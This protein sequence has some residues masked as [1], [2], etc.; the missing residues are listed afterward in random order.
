MDY[1]SALNDWKINIAANSDIREDKKRI[2][3]TIARKGP[4]LCELECCSMKDSLGYE[5]VISEHAIPFSLSDFQNSIVILTDEAVYFGTTFQRIYKV[6]KTGILLQRDLS[7]TPNDAAILKAAPVV[8][9]DKAS[10]LLNDN[11]DWLIQSIPVIKEEDTPEY[12]NSLIE[13]FY[14]LGKPFDIEFPILYARMPEKWRMKSNREIAEEL[15]KVLYEVELDGEVA[16]GQTYILQH[17]SAYLKKEFYTVTR[18]FSNEIYQNNKTVHSEFVKIRAFWKDDL[19]AFAFYAPRIIDDRLLQEEY[20]PLFENT[21]YQ[22]IWS[23]LWNKAHEVAGKISEWQ[24]D[25]LK[26]NLYD[27]NYT[28]EEYLYHTHRSLLIWTNYMFSFDLAVKLIGSLK[29]RLYDNNS[30]VLSDFFLNKTD[31]RYLSGNELLNGI[32]EQ[33]DTIIKS[34]EEIVLPSVALTD[35]QVNNQIPEPYR[36]A[37]DLKNVHDLPKCGNMSQLISALFYN[38]HFQVELKGRENWKE[39][40]DRLRFG[41]T[42]SSIYNRGFIRNFNED[43]YTSMHKAMDF[44]IDNGSIVPKYIRRK[45]N[46]ID[47]WSRV[48]RCGENE[49]FYNQKLIRF[50]ERILLY[51]KDLYGNALL[52]EY[53]IY[54]MIPVYLLPTSST[55]SMFKDEYLPWDFICQWGS[56]GPE[57][58]VMNELGDSADCR[59]LNNVQMTD[60]IMFCI[61]RQMLNK[62]DVEGYYTIVTDLPPASDRWKTLTQEKMEIITKFLTEDMGTLSIQDITEWLFY[63]EEVMV[64]TRSKL[65]KWCNKYSEL[66]EKCMEDLSF[67]DDFNSLHLVYPWK[68]EEVIKKL[69]K[70]NID[71]YD[72]KKLSMNL[73]DWIQDTRDKWIEQ[74]NNVTNIRFLKENEKRGNNLCNLLTFCLYFNDKKDK[75]MF[76][77]AKELDDYR[78]SI[79]DPL[80]QEYALSDILIKEDYDSLKK[81]YQSFIRTIVNDMD[82][83]S[84][85]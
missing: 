66:T 4:R 32:Y 16:H 31:I 71:N 51:I 38:M 53:L 39:N 72:S 40:L 83:E 64:N 15:K 65:L 35:I 5:Y 23:L 9:S 74:V 63:S 33:L 36:N 62:S 70:L 73:L 81:V 52:P 41:E 59:H 13:S 42:F 49:D 54:G 84:G 79:G 8:V 34:Q 21:P 11:V 67:I 56:Y 37:Y 75:A 76:E 30:A 68:K 6:L 82:I 55:E 50:M 60:L 46:G 43:I 27:I 25:A 57:V 78:I 69:K 61:D 47:I 7:F 24:N 1:K 12:V 58:F 3:V 77:M 20:S 2:C 80:S 44:R 28:L 22:K 18:L 19:L 45:N 10:S 48:F 29:H 17:K 85:L 26:N 14:S